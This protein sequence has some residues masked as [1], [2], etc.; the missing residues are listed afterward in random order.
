[1]NETTV[2]NPNRRRFMATAKIAGAVAIIALLGK[3]ASAPAPAPIV[4]ASSEAAPSRYRETDHT[5]KY[6]HTAGLL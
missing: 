3:K 4:S 5:R 2:T 1:M 6:Y